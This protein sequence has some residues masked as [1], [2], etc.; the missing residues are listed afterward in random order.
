MNNLY[1]LTQIVDKAVDNVR[2]TDIHTHLFSECFKSLFLYG[3][4]ELLTYHYLVAETM[5]QIDMDCKSFYSLS[6]S[7]QAQCVWD[8]LFINN[9]PVSEPA[10]S[11]ITIFSKLGIDVNNRDLN[12]YR[13]YFSSRTLKDH[14]N[15]VFDIANLKCVVMTNDP[16]DK[17]ESAVWENGYIKDDRFKAALRVD[18]VLNGWENSVLELKGLGFNVQKDLSRQTIDEIKRFLLEC[19]ERMEA[20]YCAVSLPPDFSMSDSSIRA[21]II[22]SCV[23]PVC[24]QKNIPFALMIGVKRDVNPELELAGD[25]L[26][27]VDIK[28]LE[29]LCSNYKYNKFLVTLLSLENQHELVIT[30]R[31]FRNLM[32][33][34]CWW[35]LNSPSLID[36]ITKMRFEWL[37]TSFIPQ[38][39]DC[40][41]FEQLISKWEHSKGVIA[42]VLKSKYSDLMAVGYRVTQE[43]VQRDV[44]NLFGVNFWNF[45]DKKL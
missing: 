37:G 30:A 38:H 12:Y 5:R 42:A 19:I 44:E 17:T 1:E 39:S 26:G 32:I 31:K 15:R 16:L 36:H 8:A 20:L 10:R 23:L 14:I 29:Y 40:R 3:I 27:K 28:E 13:E 2:I 45:I 41:V 25:S 6:K 35:Y 9:S 18:R 21:K 33:F 22:D 34:G 24:R 43:Q 7:D 4:D 11:I